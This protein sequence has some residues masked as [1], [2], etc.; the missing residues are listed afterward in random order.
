MLFFFFFVLMAAQKPWFGGDRF[1]LWGRG[2]GF[3]G[4]VMGGDYCA[5]PPRAGGDGQ[6]PTPLGRLPRVPRAP[7]RISKATAGG[8]FSRRCQR[9]GPHRDPLPGPKPHEG[10]GFP[11]TATPREGRDFA[12]PF[13]GGVAG[14]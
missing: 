12:P 8:P 9:R 14:G 6:S 5:G 2:W 11:P 4:S 7:E 3:P 13:P 1:A 10:K